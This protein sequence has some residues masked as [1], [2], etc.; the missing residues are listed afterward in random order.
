MAASGSRPPAAG[1]SR[2]VRAPTAPLTRSSRTISIADGLLRLKAIRDGS[3]PIDGVTLSD[4]G[5][6][7]PLGGAPKQ[8]PAANVSAVGRALF[9]GHLVAVELAGTLLL[10]ATV[11]AIAIAG[12]RRESP[13]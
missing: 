9:T 4:H 8:L 5:Q 12:T 3:S 1:R 7:E 6:V 2:S 13:A 10:I 11:G